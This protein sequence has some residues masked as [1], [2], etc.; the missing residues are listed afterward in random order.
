MRPDK[1]E[2]NKDVVNLHVFRNKCEKQLLL[3]SF[4]I[5]KVK[6]IHG[7]TFEE[8][9]VSGQVLCKNNDIV[10]SVRRLLGLDKMSYV[11]CC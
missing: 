3:C 5:C 7:Q 2:I 11:C 6:N 9:T 4:K 1:D 8:V 10:Y